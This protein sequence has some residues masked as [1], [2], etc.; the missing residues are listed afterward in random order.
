MNILKTVLSAGLGL[1][2]SLSGVE[3]LAAEESR[4]KASKPSVMKNL[5]SFKDKKYR[6]NISF[7]GFYGQNDGSYGSLDLLYPIHQ[8]NDRLV[9]VDL[10]GLLKKSPV[11]EFNV[12]GGYRWLSSDKQK[13]YGAYGFFD[14][15]M[16]ENNNWFNQLTI[17]GELKTEQLKS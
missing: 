8:K 16:S 14:R 9:F 6:P 15:K 13:L 11:K 4:S 1:G 10:R 17:G 7:S 2:L 5:F 3:V 12:G